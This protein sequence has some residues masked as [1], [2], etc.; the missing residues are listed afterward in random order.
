MVM[1]NWEY[2]GVDV[3]QLV[4]NKTM[5]KVIKVKNMDG[6]VRRYIPERTCRMERSFT[7]PS[8]LDHMQEFMCSVCGEYA[9]LQVLDER[10]RLNYCPNC[11]AKVVEQ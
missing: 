8:T 4:R 6:V 7:E 2:K 1:L 5:P 11:G 9:F 3:I 10:D